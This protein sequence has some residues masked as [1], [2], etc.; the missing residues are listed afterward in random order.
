MIN[1]LTWILEYNYKQFGIILRPITT[2]CFN[3]NTITDDDNNNNN[4]DQR[5][6]KQQKQQ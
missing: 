2:N 1:N 3:I 5:Q 4:Q 6:Q